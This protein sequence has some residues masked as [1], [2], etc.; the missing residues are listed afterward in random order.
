MTRIPRLPLAFMGGIAVFVAMQLAA[1][2]VEASGLFP[3]PLWS[4]YGFKSLLL[5]GT[6]LCM[7]LDVS[8]RSPR[9]WA[10]FGFRGTTRSDLLLYIFAIAGGVLIGAT[11]SLAIVLSPAEGMGAVVG[12]FP[13]LL[14]IILGVWIW[15]SLTE[16]VFV[17]GLVQTWMDDGVRRGV[18]VGRL[19]ISRTVLASGLF[20]GLLHLTIARAGCDALTV[21]IVCTM[22]AVGGTACAWLRE[23]SRSLL[24]AVVCH[25]FLNVGGMVGGI[26]GMALRSIL[27]L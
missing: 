24:P 19:F 13:G 4:Q 20:F 12:R 10:D 5:I 2:Q 18:R 26:I 11:G 15:S 25:V 22:T 7:A 23:R 21:L 8:S 27:G 1:E 14:D 9:R 3:S 6:L 17:R 16:E